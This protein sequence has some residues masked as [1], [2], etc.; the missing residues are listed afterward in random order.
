MNGPSTSTTEEHVDETSQI[1]QEDRQLGIQMIAE[2]S[3]DKDTECKILR[4][5][6][7]MKKVCTKKDARRK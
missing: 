7:N 1:G 2:S 5:D 4:D 6:V 3:T